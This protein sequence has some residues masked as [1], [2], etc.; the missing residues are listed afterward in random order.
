[1][2][3]VHQPVHFS[4]INQSPQDAQKK[5]LVLDNELHIREVV[6]ACL[7]VIEGWHVL[8]AATGEE[9]L[10]LTKVERPH[11]IVLD[12]IMPEMDGLLFLRSLRADPEIQTIPVILLTANVQLISPEQLIRL[13]LVAAISKPFH[14]LLLSE[15][16]SIALGWNVI[17]K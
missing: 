14:P 11:A 8:L 2:V 7:E 13:G 3:M 10:W 5:I 9:G 1:M 4:A 16:I 17:Q 6:Q 15:Q 12:L